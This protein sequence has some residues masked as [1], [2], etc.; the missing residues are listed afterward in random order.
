MTLNAHV[1]EKF[2]YKSSRTSKC[3]RVWM[4]QFLVFPMWTMSCVSEN[5]QIFI[6]Y[7]S[8]A[9]KKIRAP[10]WTLLNVFLLL[11]FSAFLSFVC[12]YQH[13]S[14]LS[15]SSFSISLLLFFFTMQI[16][17]VG[18][19]EE[20]CNIIFLL[21]ISQENQSLSPLTF[22][23]TFSA[24]RILTRT[25]FCCTFSFPPVFFCQSLAPL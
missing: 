23:D 2:V 18:V 4:S 25:L 1:Q 8:V 20:S 19:R 24:F 7:L 9:Q 15:D 16:H 10:L 14:P 21:C 17:V 6:L 13:T 5:Y 12:F 3:T 11:L 22:S